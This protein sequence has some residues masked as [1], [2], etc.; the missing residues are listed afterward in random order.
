LANIKAPKNGYAFVYVSNESD[1]MV[2]FDNM[3]V[4]HVRKH[5]LEERHY[6]AYGAKIATL[7]SCKLPDVNEGNVKNNYQYQGDFSEMDEDIGWND[8]ELR[9][10]DAQIARWMQQDPYQEFPSPY[11]AMGNDPISHVDP[12]GGFLGLSALGSVAV[13]T[14]AG[15]I[16]GGAID[17]LIPIRFVK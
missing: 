8:F 11:T 16:I 2:Y 12:T 17:R 4:A 14:L 3:Q 10:Y 15:A 6:Y 13:K 5:I 7:S 1:E 9:N